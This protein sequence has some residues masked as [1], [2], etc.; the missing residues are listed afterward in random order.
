MAWKVFRHSYKLCRRR[1]RIQGAFQ[2]KHITP[3]GVTPNSPRLLTPH[4][5]LLCSHPRWTHRGRKTRSIWRCEWHFGLGWL[6]HWNVVVFGNHN[7]GISRMF[8]RVVCRMSF[9]G[10]HSVKNWPRPILTLTT[11]TTNATRKWKHWENWLCKSFQLFKAADFYSVLF[12]KSS[13]IKIV[14]QNV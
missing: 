2:E 1:Q 10:T 6:Q 12:H 11:Q 9:R 7:D 4:C 5:W 13:W 14:Y 3:C 8:P